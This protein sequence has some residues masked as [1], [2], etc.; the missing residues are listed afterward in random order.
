VTTDSD[1]TKVSLY[2]RGGKGV[3]AVMSNLAGDPRD[4]QVRLN[5]QNLQLS[6]ELSVW[7]VISEHDVSLSAEGL[8]EQK[9]NPLD[10]RV[11]WVKPITPA[12]GQGKE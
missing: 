2:S 10:F 9:L 4:V 7:D 5:L 6:G 1:N 8:I 12:G 3:V 11:I